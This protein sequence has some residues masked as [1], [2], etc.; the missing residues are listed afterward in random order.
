M[1]TLT[2]IK[3][4]IGGIKLNQQAKRIKQTKSKTNYAIKQ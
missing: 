2:S 4:T 3:S 1:L